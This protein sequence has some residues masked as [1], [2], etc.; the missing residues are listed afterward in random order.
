M[1]FFRCKLIFP[2]LFVLVFFFLNTA[3]LNAVPDYSSNSMLSSGK[4]YKISVKE[5]GICKITYEELVS[6]GMSNPSNVRVFGYGGNQLSESFDK[7]IFDDLPEVSVY[8]YT[9]S[10]NVFGPGDFILFYAL[11]PVTWNA[12]P[13][14]L[15][16]SHVTNTYSFT[17]SY[18][19]SSDVKGSA[20]TIPSKN[21]SG[22]GHPVVGK[23]RDKYLHE[24]EQYNIC[25]TGRKFLGELFNQSNLSH[26]I[27]V[28]SSDVVA[29]DTAFISFGYA[30]VA[31]SSS[32]MS[33]KINKTD[34]ARL[35]IDPVPVTSYIYGV[36]AYGTFPF[37]P[38]NGN[39]FSVSFEYSN[40]LS[41]AYLDYFE[42][43]YNRYL[44][45]REKT[46]LYFNNLLCLNNESDICDFKISSSDNDLIVWD[47]TSH[48]G[49]IS[50][51]C[52]NVD[53]GIVVTDSID[54]YRE[55]VAVNPL[56]DN[57]I[58]VELEGVVSNQNLHSLE[59]VDMVIVSPED[60]LSQARRL[61]ETHEHY[62]ALS[63]AV[64]SDVEVY[65][66]F[67][68]GTKDATAYRR[69]MKMLYDRAGTDSSLR[70]QYL[71]LFGDGSFDNRKILKNNTSV[72]IYRLLTYQSE[73]S[74]SDVDSYTTDDYFALLDDGTG[75][76]IVKDQMAVAVGRIPVYD[77]EQAENVV[78]KIIRYIENE[79]LDDWKNQAIFLA[80]DGD[81]NEH[82]RSADTVCN[83]TQLLYPE[84]LAKKLYFDSYEQEVTSTGEYYP[85]LKKEFIDYVQSG[86]LMVNYNGHGGIYGWANE[87]VLTVDDIDNFYNT[88]LP[89]W[90]T[91]T[92]DF[93]RFDNFLVSAGEKLLTNPNG[94]AMG[95]VSTTRTV[96][97]YQN[98]ALNLALETYILKPD[99]ENSGPVSVGEALRKA[100]NSL[101]DK[102]DSNRLSFILL[103]DPAVSLNFPV[104]H[105]V[106]IKSVNGIPASSA[107]TIGALDLVSL[108]GEVT[109]ALSG[110]VDKDFNGFTKITVFDKEDIITTLSNDGETSSPAFKYRYRSK[111][112]FSGKVAV[113]DG[114]FEVKF[115]V[116]K[117]I[118]Y[119]FG[120]GRIVLY[121][122]D[123]VR[124]IDANGVF[125]NIIIGGENENAVLET[126]GP[127]IKLFLNSPFFV[128][129]DKVNGNPLF[130]AQVSDESGINTIGSGI[131]HDIIVRLDDDPKSEVVLNDY[132][133]SDLNSYTSGTVHY[134]FNDISEGRHKLFFRVWDMQ[135]NPSSAEIHF[136]V[137]GKNKIKS[138]D[139]FAYPNPASD[140]V[141][142][143]ISHN[144]PNQP[145]DI[146]LFIYDVSGLLIH[147][148]SA[149][150]VSDNSCNITL[151]F[152]IA[153]AGLYDGLYI[154]KI[155]LI[156]N[157][158]D[159][160]FKSLKLFVSK[161]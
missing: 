112:I 35:P 59:G 131:G 123:S 2:F 141:N 122:A 23:Y 21:V 37:V 113:V 101:A 110:A 128:D 58:S 52:K 106:N 157:N 82:I 111:P 55:Y 133:T 68:S 51:P 17:G 103:G 88:R 84:L 90:V 150:V 93:S 116:P 74:F 50:Y 108:S 18:F 126:E 148:S 28:H 65:N 86:V 42:L 49:L 136:T 27:T 11:G 117:D 1:C 33:V 63:V 15:S 140:Y 145:I 144:R 158:G 53:G 124:G 22:S 46:P 119:N 100:K 97:S 102:Y 99:N 16:F 20:K 38:N 115:I 70:P 12:D 13:S 67:S 25:N 6:F 132:Y 135:N 10:D 9:G 61:A 80:D 71:L 161:Q 94:G 75:D 156:D 92:C 81:G 44:V 31:S 96:L 134:Q 72:D 48:I 78:N 85:S 155:L 3:K 127:E 114:S 41:S 69:L 5:S 43:V 45:K 109:D 104:S 89:L 36:D 24:K 73:S 56:D 120:S 159:K 19:I 149:S 14:T 77:V 30:H 125:D 98:T 121:A 64:V 26:T 151:P 95:L 66:E 118:R 154:V 4:W 32:S 153:E 107:D 130:I 105:K 143:V 7:M 129:G 87:Q 54:G 29:D 160:T 47:V 40:S 62:D 8:K 57:F 76:D 34:V 152:S 139:A 147:G 91:A 83:Y 138:Y 137:D 60:F 142:F 146:Q 39:R 79:D